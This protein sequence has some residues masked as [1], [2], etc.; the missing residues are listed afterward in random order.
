MGIY[1][2][3]LRHPVLALPVIY[4]EYLH[5]GGPDG[6]PS[7][8]I[9]NEAEVLLREILF[10]RQL[11]AKLAPED[12]ERIPDFERELVAEIQ[13]VG[14]DGLGYQLNFDFQD[15]AVWE[16]IC[17][18]IEETYGQPLNAEEAEAQIGGIAAARDRS[19]KLENAASEMKRHWHPEIEWPL[20]G[21]AD[22][23]SL[24]QQYRRILKTSLT[25]DHRISVGRR[26]E[27]LNDSVCLESTQA[28]DAYRRRRHALEE[29]KKAW[30]IA[31]VDFGEI[32]AHVVSRIKRARLPF[33]PGGAGQEEMLAQLLRHLMESAN[34]EGGAA[35]AQE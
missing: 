25:Q 4:H 23:Q 8:G 28:W 30:P 20:L 12:D 21:T 18:E 6:D 1:Y 29:F 26:N 33:V 13:A 15:D 27:I 11:I 22:T 32:L 24:T 10:A 35:Q 17:G 31:V 19:I 3:L 34:A 7:K 9:E 5:Y 2:R 14:L 16:A